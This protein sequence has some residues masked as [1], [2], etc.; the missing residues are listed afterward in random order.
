[1]NTKSAWL[2][3]TI[4]T[5]ASC[6]SDVERA[7]NVR[8][9]EAGYLQKVVDDEG[10]MAAGELLFN[11]VDFDGNGRVCS[12]CHRLDAG[13]TIDADFVES[14]WQEDPNDPL[15]AAIDSDDRNGVSFDRMRSDA[16]ILIDFELP[17]NMFICGVLPEDCVCVDGQCEDTGIRELVLPRAVTSTVNNPFYETRLMTD[18]RFFDLQNQAAGAI[19]QHYEPGRQPTP[20]ELDLIAL[21]QQNDERFFSSDKL[22]KVSNGKGKVPKL[23]PGTTDAQRRGKVFFED[24]PEGLCGH[25]HGGEMLNTST[26]ELLAPPFLFGA[27]TMSLAQVS[28][29]N[30]GENPVYTYCWDDAG[31]DEDGAF[32]VCA[33][34]FFA[35][36]AV[37]VPAT[38]DNPFGGVPAVSPDPGLALTTGDRS[39]FSAFRIPSLWGVADT[40]PYFH[41]NSAADLEEMMEHY[42]AY[43]AG[44]P[45]FRDLTEQEVADIIAYLE[46]L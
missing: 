4:L 11:E 41:D 46:I 18:G 28:L 45:A 37:G 14:K 38:R 40:A 3:C 26:D 24:S 36:I 7:Q 20:E 30:P 21:F 2:S 35:D 31:S 10:E 5:L 22:F 25:C 17:E 15:F 39:D 32:D 43:F 34:G 33:D 19:N 42:V 8:D 16:T 23:P 9:I 13:G 27:R 29:L 12:T 44:P 1:M 6:A